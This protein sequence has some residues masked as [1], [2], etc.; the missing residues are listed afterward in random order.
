MKAKVSDETL[1]ALY[2]Q[3]K[4]VSEI[5]KITGYSV[6]NIIWRCSRLGIKFR[7]Q[8]TE[9]T[10]TE[11]I[12][13]YDNENLSGSEISRR[14]NISKSHVSNIIKMSRGAVASG[15][16]EDMK[17]AQKEFIDGL[18]VSLKQEWITFFEEVNADHVRAQRLKSGRQRRKSGDTNKSN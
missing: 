1:T 5:A 3:E 9:E 6:D 16:L 7:R 13:L 2:E 14:F 17:L 10:K 12:R 4:S 15:S 18:P 11:V 8:I